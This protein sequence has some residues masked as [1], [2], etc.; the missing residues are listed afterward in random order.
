MIAMRPFWKKRRTTSASRS[1]NPHLKRKLQSEQLEGRAAPG[2]FLAGAFP[3]VW[4]ESEEATNFGTLTKS[5][6]DL[7][8]VRREM[9]AQLQ[10][11]SRPQPPR[12][13]QMDIPPIEFIRG[14]EESQSD[15]QQEHPRLLHSVDYAATD[16]SFAGSRLTADLGG[17]IDTILDT[18]I[19]PFGSDSTQSGDSSGRASQGMSG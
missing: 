11:K 3:L 13:G 15:R 2:A 4:M 14:E 10:Q 17:D 19:D 12:D 16:E 5:A 9:K 7:D 6:M 1:L 8:P 18:L